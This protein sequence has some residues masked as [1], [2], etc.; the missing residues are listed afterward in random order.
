ML[1]KC[2][3]SERHEAEIND[4]KLF[5]EIKLFFDSEVNEGIYKC[6]KVETPYHSWSDGNDKINFYA[7][8][9][10]ICQSCGCLWEFLYPD[11]PSRGF[12]R[13]FP[14]GVYYKNDQK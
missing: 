7:T 4:Y 12:V 10:Y 8:N 14:N 2:E 13:K 1:K 3:C 6:I 9:W 11:F 5:E